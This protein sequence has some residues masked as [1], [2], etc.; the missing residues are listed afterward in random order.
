MYKNGTARIGKDI[1]DH[2]L[3]NKREKLEARHLKTKLEKEAYLEMK[4][5]E[6]KVLAANK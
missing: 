4:V 6:Q 1:T 2:Y 5:E 3:S